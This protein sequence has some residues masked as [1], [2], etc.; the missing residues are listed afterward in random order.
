MSTSETVIRPK[1]YPAYKESGG[2]WLGDVPEDWDLRQLG[3]FGRFSKGNGG[4]KEDEIRDGVPCI[5]YG[6]IYT[7]HQFFI[8][9]S[10]S[11]ISR[12]RAADYTPIQYGDILFA[13]SGETIEE[14]G[15]SA[16]NLIE[17]EACC[18]GDVI[19]F[20]P[21]IDL[22]ARFMGYA[23]D[24]RHAAFQKSCM[25]RGIT[26]MH[27]YGD[28]LKYMWV[29]LPPLPEQTAIVRFL[30]HADWRI[31]R[32][33]RAKR[34]LIKLLEEQ[35][36]VIIHR[37]VTRGLDPNVRLKP[38]GVEWLG[39]VPEHWDVLRGKYIGRLFSSPSVS[40]DDLTEA[41]GDHVM[42]LKVSDLARTDSDLML[43]ASRRYVKNGKR[44][45]GRVQKRVCLVF[46]KRGAAIYTNKVAIV[47]SDF[48][49]DP[50]LMGWEIKEQ[51]D[52]R[53][54]ALVLQARTLADLAD[55]SSVPQINNKHIYPMAL[56]APPRQEQEAILGQL[57]QEL[58]GLNSATARTKHEIS[59][60][61]EYRTRLIADV[62]TGKL[63]VREAA[64]NVPEA[65]D[66][67]EGVPVADEALEEAEG[68]DDVAAEE[69]ADEEVA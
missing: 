39:D 12:E 19:V 40:D 24:C 62:V 27:L 1:P 46:P 63:D 17:G 41:P 2:P 52:P 60:L 25:G 44:S 55:V 66:E 54:V 26:V 10:R 31:R 37:A 47:E 11:C 20:R 69:L 30:D 51:F 21:S 61:R 8:E 5:R 38:S 68:L 15:K 9:R 48:L 50:N 23:T 34:K 14:I 43:H 59:L 18:G 35:K 58:V 28:E 64:A 57:D 45:E 3:R 56:P 7:Q 67:L 36:Q 33:V 4:T 22:T 53:Y 65:A 29:A 42:Y 49:L 16:V 32:Y 13:G 6:D